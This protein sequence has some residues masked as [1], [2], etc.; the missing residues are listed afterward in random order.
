MYLFIKRTDRHRHEDQGMSVGWTD[1]R[2]DDE[3]GL[4]NNLVAVAA[5]IFYSHVRVS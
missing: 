1:V 2:T 3:T 5:A 4:A